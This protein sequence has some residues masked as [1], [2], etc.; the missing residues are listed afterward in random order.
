MSQQEES[1]ISHLVELR[2][3]LLR[4]LLWPAPAQGTL[5][6]HPDAAQAPQN[7]QG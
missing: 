7:P 1:F 2:D 5:P 3:R 4:C 6:L